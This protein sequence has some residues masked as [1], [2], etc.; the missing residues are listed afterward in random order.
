VTIC[1]I[2][3]E[4]RTGSTKINALPVQDNALT[5]CA[6][7]GQHGAE[8]AELEDIAVNNDPVFLHALHD[9]HEA[10]ISF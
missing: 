9:T 1:S 4:D 2:L 10:N 3:G 6:N 7:E 8:L 5:Y